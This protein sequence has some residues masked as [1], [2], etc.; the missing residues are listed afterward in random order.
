MRKLFFAAWIPMMTPHASFSAEALHQTAPMLAPAQQPVTIEARDKQGSEPQRVTD[1]QTILRRFDRVYGDKKPK[2]AVFWNRVF[3]DQVS[4]WQSAQRGV[5]SERGALTSAGRELEWNNQSAVQA[6]FRVR[7]AR[8]DPK[9]AFELQSGLVEQLNAAGVKVL[10]RASIMRITDNRLETGEFSRL[11]PDQR[12]LEMRSLGEFADLLLV[13]RELS[14]E[15]YLV[16]ILDVHTG[17]IVVMLSSNGVPMGT[18]ASY[19]WLAT[20]QGFKKAAKTIPLA[21]TGRELA[22][23]LLEKMVDSDA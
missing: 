20:K 22:L 16:E 5:A 18:D 9:P 17:E 3:D 14:E 19:Q 7:S 15:R 4:D 8:D 6:E 1:A 21:E 12:R 10:D 23:Q 13:F 2:M 11:S